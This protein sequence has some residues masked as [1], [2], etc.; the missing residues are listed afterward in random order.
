MN[1]VKEKV[2]P[3]LVQHRR[4]EGKG[5]DIKLFNA[6]SSV[7]GAGEMDVSPHRLVTTSLSIKESPFPW[8]RPM[9]GSG[10]F[11]SVLVAV[12]VVSKA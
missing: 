12:V 6:Y 5:A 9:K 1:H 4:S 2:T 11:S 7:L 10:S 8:K 3:R